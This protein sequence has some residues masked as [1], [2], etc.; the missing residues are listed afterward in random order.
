M[1][2]L[3]VA[4]AVAA[5]V[6]IAR[7]DGAI[8]GI[9]VHGDDVAVAS[10]KLGAL[11][12]RVSGGVL[13]V[14]EAADGVAISPD[15][16]LALFF[17]QDLGAVFVDVDSGRRVQTI[18]I[19]GGISTAAWSA[20]RT[21]V[22]LGTRWGV[23]VV[24]GVSLAISQKRDLRERPRSLGFDKKVVIAALAGAEARIDLLD[25]RIVRTPIEDLPAK[26]PGDCVVEP[27]GA[28]R[29][30]GCEDGVIRE[31]GPQDP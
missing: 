3:L 15:G 11:V 12:D 16:R 26:I 29:L 6:D 25:T 28:S 21:A 5:P 7:V 24:D 9:S 14:T 4:I 17:G 23:L 13:A 18:H 1:W 31:L 27:D 2:G 20:D 10:D 19:A 8:R 30:V 22:A